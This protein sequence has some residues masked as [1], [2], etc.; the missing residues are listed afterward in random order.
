LSETEGYGVGILTTPDNDTISAYLIDEEG[1]RQESTNYIVGLSDYDI[2]LRLK[3][4]ANHINDGS[5]YIAI[6]YKFDKIDKENGAVTNLRG[7]TSSF[8]AS[9]SDWFG[10]D[11]EILVGRR[12]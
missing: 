7:H 8:W 3:T 9:S 5:H 4:K 10:K 1:E 2:R 12:H 6:A 11:S